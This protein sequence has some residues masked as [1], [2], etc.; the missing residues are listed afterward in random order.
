[1]VKLDQ[2]GN[3]VWNRYFGGTRHDYL[4]AS[5]TTQ[6]GGFLLAGTSFSNQSGEKKQTILADPMSG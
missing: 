2:N 1:M 5:T 3:K 4:M 6:E